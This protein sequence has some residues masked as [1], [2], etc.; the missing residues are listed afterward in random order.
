M[1][2]ITIAAI[3]AKGRVL[4][5]LV[6]AVVAAWL[7]ALSIVEVARA[8]MEHSCQPDSVALW[9]K[10]RIHVRCSN[11]VGGIAYFAMRA[12]GKDFP[13]M[14]SLLTEALTQGWTV[15]V[16]YDP[17]DLSG[18]KFGCQN[19]DCRILKAAGVGP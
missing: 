11:P 18:E 19:A 3:Q 14:F 5:K 1:P 16:R 2:I 17:A 4:L 10:Q 9:P 13:L 6:T 7:L 12:R 15:Y 8:D